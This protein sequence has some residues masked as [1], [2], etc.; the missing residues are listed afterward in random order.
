M[1][2]LSLSPEV[3]AKAQELEK[4]KRR[5]ERKLATFSKRMEKLLLCIDQ[6]EQPNSYPTGTCWALESR[7]F[8]KLYGPLMYREGAD[9]VQKITKVVLTAA[10]VAKVAEIRAATV[11]AAEASP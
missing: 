5:R 9:S 10:G 4:S 3:A 1:S 6:P 8:V 7:G 11:Q 2:S